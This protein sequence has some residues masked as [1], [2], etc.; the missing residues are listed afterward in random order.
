MDKLTFHAACASAFEFPEFYGRNMDAWIDCMSSLTDE[1]P[2]A[3]FRLGKDEYL[4][5]KVPD[6]GSLEKRAPEVA[7]SLISCTTIVNQ[8]YTEFGDSARIVLVVE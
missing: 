2:L 8:R 5:L 3:G 4:V 7:R 1:H 6:F